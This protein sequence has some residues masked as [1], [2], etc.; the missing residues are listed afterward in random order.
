[1]RFSR[2]RTMIKPS[3]LFTLCIA[4][5]GCSRDASVWDGVYTAAQAARGREIYDS[6]CGNCHS[7]HFDNPNRRLI[8][9]RFLDDWREDSLKS[10]FDKITTSMPSDAPSTLSDQ[11]YLD[12]LTFI[13]EK[14]GFPKGR[15]EL[16]V[17]IL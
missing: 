4:I 9:Q 14:N 17:D 15:K 3:V 7:V 1:M 10:L 2:L 11:Q 13:L 6:Y 5:S 8:G 16:G 12:V